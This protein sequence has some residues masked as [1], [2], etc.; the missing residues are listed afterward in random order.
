MIL[1]C[2]LISSGRIHISNNK[3]L[4]ASQEKELADLQKSYNKNKSSMSEGDAREAK[5][6]I[7]ALQESI[8]ETKASIADLQS[9][10]NNIEV[11]KLE[12]SLDKLQTK[13]NELEDAISLKEAK[14]LSATADDYVALIKNSQKQIDNLERQNELLR[15]QQEQYST[16]SEKYEELRKQIEDNEAAIR[17]AE[18]AQIEW[19][20]AIADIPIQE[21][22]KALELTEAISDYNKS[23]VDLK[24]ASGQVVTEED[25][26]RQI[27][28]ENDKLRDLQEERELIY[29]YYQ[30]ALES[31]DGTY[32]GKTADEWKKEWVE[33]DTEINQVKI[34]IIELEDEIDNIDIKRLTNEMSELE[35]QASKLQNTLDMK[36]LNGQKVTASDYQGLISNSQMQ[37]ANLESQNR[38]LQQQLLEV[39]KGSDKYYEIQEQIQDNEEAIARCRKEQ[40]QWN[41]EMKNLPVKQLQAELEVIESQMDS[42]QN[43]IDIKETKGIKATEQDYRKLISASQDQIINLSQQNALLKQQQAQCEVG[44]EKYNELQ[45]QINSNT[46]AIEQ[47]RKNQA[48]WNVAIENL[49]LERL[50]DALDLLDAIDEKTKSEV[51]LKVA[52]GQDLT[53]ADYQSQISDN[54]NQI[55]NLENQRLEATM[56]YKKALASSDGVYGG[57]T[58]DEWKAIINETDASINNLRIENE[59][60]KD[61]LRDDVYWRQFER[62]HDESER[63]RDVLDGISDLID[64]DM[65]FDS[66][67]NLTQY[68]IDKIALLTKQYELARKEVRNYTND[69][70]NLNKL[71]A[72]GQYSEEEYKEKLA[73][74]QSGLLDAASDM[75]NYQ[76]SIIDMYKERDQAELDALYEIIDKRREALDAKKSYYSF[77]KT[78]RGKT[79]DIQELQAQ[80]AALEGITG[81]EAAAKRAKL[82]AELSDAQEDLDDTLK[83][84]EFEIAQES[85]DAMKDTLQDAFDDRWD[86][87]SSDMD[88]VQKLM[89]EANQIAESSAAQ[90]NTSLNDLLNY[91]GINASATEIDAVS[92]IGYNN[93][94]SGGSDYPGNSSNANNS[95]IASDISDAFSDAIGDTEKNVDSIKSILE[96]IYNGNNLQ[97]GS[98]Q[99]LFNGWNGKTNYN[100]D[101]FKNLFSNS[102]NMASIDMNTIKDV[103]NQIQNITPELIGENIATT[104]DFYSEL[105]KVGDRSIPA[106]EKLTENQ[107]GNLSMN[108]D[109][110]FNVEDMDSGILDNPQK[111]NTLCETMYKYVDQRMAAELRRYGINKKV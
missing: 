6:E 98:I 52:T 86:N 89:N 1:I 91:Y 73:E 103:L 64:D 27:K 20:N 111:L 88:E 101:D 53:E 69:I 92:G 61:S 49:P 17:E 67:G 83:E 109:K 30:K 23:V 2:R 95:G 39:E 62:M 57:K 5:A 96:S 56:N 106:L 97:F 47:A 102:F 31:E 33:L 42:I 71:Y 87:I 22:E 65:T 85:L 14:G 34:D 75:K 24:I 78:I 35:H 50:E 81:A 60:L 15:K 76:D 40:A 63:T 3:S 59:E 68:G 94:Y 100:I 44:S 37:V 7:Y 99:N 54:N 41:E 29:S 18:K 25:Y 4:L 32:A 70:E 36:E 58:A 77:D 9:E 80:L 10:L 93:G 38:L 45:Q 12:I 84:H 28:D 11:K 110:M 48:E 74:L 13:A 90:V 104:K 82:Q 19:N 8:L 26:L 51:E 55:N 108:I 107:V 79:K 21:L 46:N 43:S 105:V 66:D 72:D 16:N